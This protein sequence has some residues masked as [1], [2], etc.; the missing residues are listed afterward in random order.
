MKSSIAKC[1]RRTRQRC[2][3]LYVSAKRSIN[4]RHG[5]VEKILALQLRGSLA[6]LGTKEL[7]ET[8]IAYEPV[9]AI[10]TGRTATPAQAQEA[11]AF[12]RHTLGKIADDATADKIRIQYGGSVK[13]DNARELMEQSDIDGAL[14]G[15]ASLDAR[16]FA[17]I[18]KA[19]L[20]ND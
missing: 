4:A 11:H 8:V 3:R 10:G 19:A 2:G 20:P 1:A 12:I 13:P 17:E 16:S 5:N 18:V 7:Q 9:W 6:N 14:V 15:G